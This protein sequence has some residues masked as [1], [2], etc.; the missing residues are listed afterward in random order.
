[1]NYLYLEELVV[2]DEG[3]EL[4]EGLPAA[5]AHPHQQRVPALPTDN[6]GGIFFC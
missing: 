6:P 2:G 4:G 5:A 1:M 3:G